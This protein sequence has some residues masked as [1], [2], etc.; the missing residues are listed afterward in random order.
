MDR[1]WRLEMKIENSQLVQRFYLL[2]R[3]APKISD[4]LYGYSFMAFKAPTE[5]EESYFLHRYSI[6]KL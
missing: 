1:E 5:T 6:E 2:S 3:D 4:V